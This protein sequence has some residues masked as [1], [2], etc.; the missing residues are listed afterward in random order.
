MVQKKWH[1]WCM[2]VLSVRHV[3]GDPDGDGSGSL[4]CAS[5]EMRLMQIA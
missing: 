5:C 1:S 2:V 3:C 4:N